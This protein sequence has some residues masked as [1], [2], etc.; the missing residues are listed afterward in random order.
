M[1]MAQFTFV[2]A[3]KQRDI[4][5]IAKI[6]NKKGMLFTVSGDARFLT[7]VQFFNV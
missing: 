3:L 7:N 5:N 1:V 6:F 2:E 4:R